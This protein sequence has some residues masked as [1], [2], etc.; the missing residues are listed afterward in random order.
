[1]SKTSH[2]FSSSIDYEAIM[3]DMNTNMDAMSSTLIHM[4]HQLTDSHHQITL[5]N[6]ENAR[7]KAQCQSLTKALNT[8]NGTIH[9][10]SSSIASSAANT[11]TTTTTATTT[12]TTTTNINKSTHKRP[13]SSNRTIQNIIPKNELTGATSLYDLDEMTSSPQIS[14]L[15]QVMADVERNTLTSV[16]ST[17]A[18]NNNNNNYN[19]NNSEHIERTS[20]F[21][22]GLNVVP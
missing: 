11:P 17:T 15:N 22:N 9:T 13:H 8:P 10:D 14:S 7:L 21:E 4:R 2:N 19:H 12:T 18:N 20:S 6:E 5:L 1:M 16:N 3:L